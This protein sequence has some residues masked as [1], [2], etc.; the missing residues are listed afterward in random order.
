MVNHQ[1]QQ[2]KQNSSSSLRS[3]YENETDSSNTH[4]IET[5]NTKEFLNMNRLHC[6]VYQPTNVNANEVASLTA[7][8]TQI[9]QPLVRM[10]SDI[11]NKIGNV[12]KELEM[13]RMSSNSNNTNTNTNDQYLIQENPIVNKTKS[14]SKSKSPFT[15]KKQRSQS[16]SHSPAS[17]S[18]CGVCD[19]G[20]TRQ[21]SLSNKNKSKSRSTS[22]SSSHKT[23]KKKNQMKPN[24]QQQQQFLQNLLDK[25]D[26]IDAKQN[27]HVTPS[28]SSL[29]LIDA[30]DNGPLLFDKYLVSFEIFLF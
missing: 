10:Q 17:I 2:Q 12:L 5:M 16:R 1:Q 8:V 20:R 13:L 28:T 30:Y 7:A 27:I 26:D 21:R 11:E 14:K 4:L 3:S 9:T 29:L 23:N 19:R 18:S 22:S 6:G 15:N 25:E 24:Q